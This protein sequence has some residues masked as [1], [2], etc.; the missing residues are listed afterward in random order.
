M[1]KCIFNEAW[2][3]EPEFAEWLEGV[4]TDKYAYRCRACK[5]IKQLGTMGKA[6]VKA[7]SRGEKHEVALRTMLSTNRA[8]TARWSGFPSLSKSTSSSS[9]KKDVPQPARYILNQKY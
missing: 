9:A 4:P 5:S 2:R 8:L 6:A 7:H 1:G 3:S